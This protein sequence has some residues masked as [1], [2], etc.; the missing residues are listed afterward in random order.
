M[1][2]MEKCGNIPVLAI[3][4]ITPPHLSITCSHIYSILTN[5]NNVFFF[6]F[7]FGI[8][9]DIARQKI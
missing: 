6:F 4:M 3:A 9:P 8:F 1:K 5:F 2:N 7:F